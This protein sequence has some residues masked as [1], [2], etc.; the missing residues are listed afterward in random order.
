GI[1]NPK[2]GLLD[3]APIDANRFEDIAKLPSKLELYAELLGVLQAAPSNLVGV[4]QG[5]LQEFVGILDAQ[6]NKL[7]EA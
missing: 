5:K 6:V 2:A 7:Q 1:P 3:G 4:L